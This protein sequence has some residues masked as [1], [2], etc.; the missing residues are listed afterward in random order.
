[1]TND[2]IEIQ[3]LNGEIQINGRCIDWWAEE[4]LFWRSKWLADHP[5]KATYDYVSTAREDEGDKVEILMFIPPHM[6]D[7]E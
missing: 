1:M 6:G 7:L 3:R 4:M 2:Q 5:E